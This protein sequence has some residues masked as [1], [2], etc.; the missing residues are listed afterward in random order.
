MRE[1]TRAKVE[2]G[3]GRCANRIYPDQPM[4]YVLLKGVR[5]KLIRCV[6]CAG[7][8]PP[9]LPLNIERES[10]PTRMASIQQ[11]ASTMP[12]TR[13]AASAHAEQILGGWR[14]RYGE[15]R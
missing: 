6:E 7:P 3:C 2:E 9:D 8:A 5:R 13:R 12:R 11:A 10:I 4:L 1:W 15:N 14:D